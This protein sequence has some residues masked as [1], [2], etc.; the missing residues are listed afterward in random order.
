MVPVMRSRFASGFSIVELL[1]IVALIGIL[2]RTA[3]ISVQRDQFDR[4]RDALNSSVRDLASWFDLIRTRAATGTVCTVTIT[5]NG[6]LLSGGT[7]ASVSP[8][9]CGSTLTLDGEA[10]SLTGQLALANTPNAT[11]SITLTTE[12]GAQLA[13]TASVN[14]FNGLEVALSSASVNL[15]RC[16]AISNGT[17]SLLLGAASTSSGTCT[18]TGPL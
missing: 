7:L 17:G 11:A 10:A 5:P 6:T 4:R 8:S 16:L 2:S 18:Y 14:G 3:L 15:K 1:V 13:S 12:G 9:S